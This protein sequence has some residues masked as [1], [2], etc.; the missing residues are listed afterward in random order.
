MDSASDRPAEPARRSPYRGNAPRTYW[1]SA[2]SGR[3]PDG[4]ENLYAKKFA[5]DET[6]RIATAG[7]CFAQHIARNMRERGFQVLDLE[8]APRQVST[9]T[10]NRYGYGI[11]SARFGNIYYARQ[12]LQLVQEALG[13]RAPSDAVWTRDGRYY[14]ALRPAV[15]P[16]GLETAE[17]VAA[18]RRR[19][20]HRVKM[21]LNRVDV[22]VFTFGLTEG[23]VH[24]ESGTV[25]PTAPGT[26]AGDFDP[27]VY[28]FR[29]FGYADVYEDFVAFREL[30]HS[31]NPDVKFL[32]T[33]SPVPLAATAS[34]GHVLPA[35][36]YS[37]S[38]LRAVAG[39][40][41][42]RFDDVDYFPSYEIVTSVFAGNDFFDET[43]RN[44][45]P[46]GVDLVMDYFFAEHRPPN[47]HDDGA[48]AARAAEPSPQR[49]VEGEEVFCEEA[50]LEAFG[51]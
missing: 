6:T 7:S 39:D 1:K 50:L 40:L 41:A 46:E 19:H 28:E 5:I 12:L 9:S 30:V 17:L 26:I 27:D 20:V 15:E 14:D 36:V 49:V 43:G 23:W 24:R 25:Y 18:H 21:L 3:A 38:V 35:T 48:A 16:T 31:V 34:G 8:P 2:V 33:V 11:Y 44:V 29:N 32:I 4:L 51:P 45:R 10:A 13:Q 42:T 47:G 37:K 22:F